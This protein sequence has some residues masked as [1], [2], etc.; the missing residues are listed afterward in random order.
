MHHNFGSTNYYDYE[1]ADIY[2]LSN[3]NHYSPALL[4]HLIDS[5][6]RSANCHRAAAFWSAESR[7]GRNLQWLRNILS[8][9][10]CMSIPKPLQQIYD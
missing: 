4:I 7:P 8:S 3:D 1:Q 9:C 2:N 10:G 5:N 6:Q